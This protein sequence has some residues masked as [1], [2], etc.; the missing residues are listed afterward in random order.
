MGLGCWQSVVGG[1]EV[2]GA[3]ENPIE[4][5]VGRLH[6]QQIGEHFA[7]RHDLTALPQVGEC[8]DL[9]GVQGNPHRRRQLG[10]VLARRSETSA[11]RIVVRCA[12]MNWVT[13]IS[14]STG[15]AASGT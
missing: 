9:D 8:G 11:K 14:A 15:H 10:P 3:D 5:E 1:Q 2:A 7:L 13:R 4:F 12:S 6:S